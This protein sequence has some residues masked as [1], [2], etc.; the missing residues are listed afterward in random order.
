MVSCG[1]AGDEREEPMDALVGP[2][3]LHPMVNH[4][5]ERNTENGG[6]V[7]ALDDGQAGDRMYLVHAPKQTK[8]MRLK[9][10]ISSLNYSFCTIK[11]NDFLQGK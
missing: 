10:V 11:V 2:L 8:K 1:P 3:D 9:L 5:I 7:L 6:E 4:R